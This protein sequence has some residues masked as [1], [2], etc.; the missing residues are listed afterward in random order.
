VAQA[1]ATRAEVLWQNLLTD[2][3]A[4]VSKNDEAHIGASCHP[5]TANLALL[6]VIP[7]AILA[8]VLDG[9]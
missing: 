9:T 8:E 6:A 7:Q 5:S 2:A 4:A 3:F 1:K